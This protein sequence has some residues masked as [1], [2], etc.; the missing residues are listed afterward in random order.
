M[1]NLTS[2][3]TVTK[4]HV[5]A[6]K[7]RIG[8]PLPAMPWAFDDDHDAWRETM[9]AFC[10]D[11][12][13][14]GAADRSIQAHYDADLVREV[15]ELGAFGL[16]LPEPHGAGADLRTLCIT[17]EELAYVDSSLAV[18]THVAAV[19]A[20]LLAKLI[21]DRP[22]LHSELVPQLASGEIMACFGLTEPSGGSDAANVD[23]VARRDGDGWILDG[24]KQFITNSGT[25]LTKYAVVFARTGGNEDRRAV[26]AFLVPL[27]TPGVTVAPAY[28]KLGWRASDTHPIFLDSVRLPA[29]ALLDREGNGMARALGMLTW[30]RIPFAAIGL[31]LARACLDETIRFASDRTSFGSRLIDHQSVGFRLAQMAADTATAG[32]QTYD[33]AW[34][35]DHGRP[36]DVEAASSKLV[37]TEIA[38]QVAYEATQLHG[39]YG[40]VLESAVTRHYQDARVLT[41][42]EGTSE[43]QRMLLARWLT[44]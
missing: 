37:A 8:N 19:S 4:A 12:V 42:A 17:V 18:T 23:T 34:K 38:N 20:Y 35:Y 13:A 21:E 22:D 39:G 16:L 26:S 9:R 25:P 5:K 30:A 36:Y 27:D 44:P 15:A 11:R 40:F 33:A 2:S 24:A 1:D 31:G 10:R 32:L 3:S 41:I 43:V 6:P 29:S 14:P 28:Q 7:H